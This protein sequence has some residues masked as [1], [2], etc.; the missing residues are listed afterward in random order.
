MK[1]EEGLW[2]RCRCQSAPVAYLSRGGG[3]ADSH[4]SLRTASL[5]YSQWT[6]YRI[7]QTANCRCVFAEE[8]GGG[9]EI[10]SDSLRDGE[11]IT[12]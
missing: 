1:A 4:E 10:G 2:S 5:L 3:C 9:M 11:L 7:Y 8:S 6:G 12:D